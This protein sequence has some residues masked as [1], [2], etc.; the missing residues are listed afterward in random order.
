MTSGMIVEGYTKMKTL[1]EEQ[2]VKRYRNSIQK[3]MES[4][5]IDEYESKINQKRSNVESSIRTWQKKI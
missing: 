3:N 1:Q 2:I 5:E 4:D